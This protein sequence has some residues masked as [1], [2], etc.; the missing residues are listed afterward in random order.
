MIELN[1]EQLENLPKVDLNP[2]DYEGDNAAM[3]LGKFRRAARRAK[4]KDTEVSAVLNLAMQKSYD[5]IFD[6]IANF[7]I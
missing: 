6:F 5:E 1:T 7:C 2:Y 3:V 4:W